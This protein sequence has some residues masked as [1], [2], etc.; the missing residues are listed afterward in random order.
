ML[1]LSVLIRLVDELP[2]GVVVL[3]RHGVVVHYNRYEAEVARRSPDRVIGRSFFTEVAPCT[4]IRELG[5]TF[6]DCIGKR[7]LNVRLDFSFP[8]PFADK[9]RDVRIALTSFEDAGEPYGCLFIED[10]SHE[11]AV[12][13]MR[14]T[15]GELLVH[16]MKNPLAVLHANLSLLRAKAKGDERVEL[17]DMALEAGRRLDRMV[18]NLLDITRLESPAFPLR[19]ERIDARAL[20]ETVV[21]DVGPLG[22]ER[23]VALAP[24]VPDHPVAAVLDADVVRRA[25]D[26]LVEN[27]V[28]FA[29]RFVR[30][31]VAAEADRV[32]FDV[33]DD[34]PGI[35][36]E[37]RERIFDKYADASGATTFATRHNRGLGL[38]F[39]R[40]AARA[41]A[42]DVEVES[43]P[44]KGTSFV[45]TLP[46]E[47]PA[48]GRACGKPSSTGP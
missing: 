22:R 37:L 16:D 8:F 1:P 24:E 35:A 41:H 32:R 46:T 44:G 27:A 10:V 15:L 20:V 11:R 6:H 17:L 18:L 38:T 19:R 21:R 7:P 34:G 31:R 5:G 14:E 36:P 33:A 23:A 13:R 30:V 25:L 48:G 28:R 47:P 42:G 26:N 3:D 40:L 29:R 43:E 4:N 12:E 39:V 45:L 2:L 9:P